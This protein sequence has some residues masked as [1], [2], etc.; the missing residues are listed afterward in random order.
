[1]VCRSSA[2]A[3]ASYGRSPAEQIE[4]MV[5]SRQAFRVPGKKVAAWLKAAGQSPYD[6]LLGLFVEIYHDVAAKNQIE[7]TG[8]GFLTKQVEPLE[9]HQRTQILLDSVPARP[10]PFAAQPKGSQTFLRNAVKPIC[11]VHSELRFIQHLCRDIGRED[12]DFSC[13]RGAEFFRKTH[14]DCVGLFTAGTRGAPDI[15]D[16]RVLLFRQKGRSQKIEMRLFPEKR[17]VVG[18]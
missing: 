17:R 8:I 1:M 14:R 5:D 13:D 16:S 3:L 4:A 11:P 7:P 15:D 2:S 9:I 6:L 18:C 10:I 12:T